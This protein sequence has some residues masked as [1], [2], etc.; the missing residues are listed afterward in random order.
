M[1]VD[2]LFYSSK[3]VF[4]KKSSLESYFNW[5]YGLRLKKVWKTLIH[6]NT[7]LLQNPSAKGTLFAF[8]TT[9]I[10]SVIPFFFFSF[11]FFSFP[12][13]SLLFFSY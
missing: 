6:A 12:F 2:F 7:N 11:L 8:K 3:K 13:F 1:L 5:L 9:Q 4:E 10:I